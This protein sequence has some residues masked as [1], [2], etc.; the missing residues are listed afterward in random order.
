MP[1]IEKETHKLPSNLDSL[2]AIEQI[3]E[4]LRTK[5]LIPE[6]LYGNTLVALTEAATNS[7][8]HGNKFD[9]KKNIIISLEF[10]TKSYSISVCDLGIGF[11]FNNVPDPTL[12]ENIEKPDGRGIFIMKSLCD[13]VLFEDEG[14]KVLMEFSY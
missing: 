12:A 9:T 5:G 1:I 3:V 4:D 7:I 10:R 6:E 2:T 11:D 13:E 8:K 14:R